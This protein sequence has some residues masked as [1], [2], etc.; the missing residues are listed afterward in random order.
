[1]GVCCC[2]TGRQ[3]APQRLA[4][5]HTALATHPPLHALV[6]GQIVSGE[7]YSW[8]L[9]WHAMEAEKKGEEAG[10]GQTASS[11][12]ATEGEAEAAGKP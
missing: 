5:S 1:M 11:A 7:R 3:P 9:W 4:L 8:V 6:A 10:G 12:A 2:V